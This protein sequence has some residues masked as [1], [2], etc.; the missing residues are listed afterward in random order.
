MKQYIRTKLLFEGEADRIKE[1]TEMLGTE[2]DP[3]RFERILPLQGDDPLKKWGTETDAE[4]TD[5]IVYR[6]GTKAEYSFDTANAMPFPVCQELSRRYPDLKMT[7][8]YA[9]Q[10]YGNDCGCYEAA[11]GS[12]ELLPQKIDDPFVFA[13]DIWEIDPEEQRYEEMINFY[14]E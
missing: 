1:I 3:I 7:V 13:C 11:A 8:I 5:R 2:S 14:E 10:D 12:D 4:E 6:D 9:S